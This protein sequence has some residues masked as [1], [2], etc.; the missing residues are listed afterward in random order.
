M[1]TCSFFF[2]VNLFY[3]LPLGLFC[4]LC[5]YW[6]PHSKLAR[7]GLSCAQPSKIK[8]KIKQKNDPAHRQMFDR[9]LYSSS[10]RVTVKNKKLLYCWS[11]ALIPH[12]FSYCPCYRFWR[13]R[14]LKLEK[15]GPLWPMVYWAL[16]CLSASCVPDEW[17]VSCCHYPHDG[18]TGLDRYI[19]HA[20]LF[21]GKD[22]SRLPDVKLW[23]WLTLFIWRLEA[24]FSDSLHTK[25]GIF[26]CL[27]A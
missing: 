19:L 2:L 26:L 8:R 17:S 9:C 22:L 6:V 27:P 11:C 21:L 15:H 20:Y 14:S 3:G 23:R 4:R 25:Q 5:Q 10:Y 12:I 1:R 13:A 7:N 18:H 24:F 16:F